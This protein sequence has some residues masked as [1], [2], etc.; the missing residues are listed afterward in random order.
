MGHQN[1]SVKSVRGHENSMKYLNMS[2]TPSPAII[3]DP[4]HTDHKEISCLMKRLLFSGN[5]CF[6]EIP[7][8]K[9]C[10]KITRT[11]YELNFYSP[12]QFKVDAYD[13]KEALM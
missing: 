12:V 10:S 6:Y 1:F 8:L 13:L 9:A 3:S 4:S 11:D 2:S 5:L 7:G